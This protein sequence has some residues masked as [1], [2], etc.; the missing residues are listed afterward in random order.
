MQTQ[1]KTPNPKKINNQK[2]EKKKPK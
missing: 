2:K 1:T